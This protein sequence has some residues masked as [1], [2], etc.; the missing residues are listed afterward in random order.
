MLGLVNFGNT[1][2]F[3]SALQALLCITDFRKEILRNSHKHEILQELSILCENS[4]ILNPSSLKHKLGQMSNFF[5]QHGQQDSHECLITILDTI[6]KILGKSSFV[7][8]IFSGN[9]STQ[10]VCTN[11]QKERVTHES[12]IDLS[13]PI[14][15][16]NIFD[17]IRMAYETRELLNDPIIC[18]NCKA[19][20][21]TLK[22]VFISKVPNILILTLFNAFNKSYNLVIPEIISIDKKSYILLCIIYHI[23][24][25]HNGHYFVNVRYNS[26]WYNIDDINIREIP[27]PSDNKNAYVLIY[28]KANVIG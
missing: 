24:N 5:N 25:L 15:S 8:R 18:E 17:S 27:F 4:K 2:Y 6:D 21:K 11:C 7:N 23:G 28:E 13:V 26:K 12:F 22:N 14:Y 20:T 9:T 3:N 1:C 19:S 10:L 16:P